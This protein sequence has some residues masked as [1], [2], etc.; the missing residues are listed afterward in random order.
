V[1]LAALPFLIQ[2]A[3]VSDLSAAPPAAHAGDARTLV[4]LPEMMQQHMLVNM[5]G[6]LAALDEILEDLAAHRLDRAA[7]V[8]ERQLGMSSLEAHGAAHMAHFMPKAM[9]E[10]GEGMHRAA[11]RFALRAQEGDPA[12]ALAALRE[13]TAACVACHAAYRIR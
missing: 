8:A 9:Q 12:Q 5:R 7:E 6:H 2:A 13:V 3:P 4:Q 11:S 1:V 10:L